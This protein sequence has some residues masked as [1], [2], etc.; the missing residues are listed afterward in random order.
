MRVVNTVGTTPPRGPGGTVS[1]NVVA[2]RVVCCVCRVDVE[3]AAQH[4]QPSADPLKHLLLRRHPGVELGQSIHSLSAWP[5][6][7][8]RLLRDR[9]FRLTGSGQIHRMSRRVRRARDGLNVGVC[10]GEERTEPHVATPTR[11]IYLN[12]PR[13]NRP[14]QI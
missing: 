10:H 12:N 13:R 14:L 2:Q 3:R 6:P 9:P 11:P 8:S 7:N 5:P 4:A 1:G